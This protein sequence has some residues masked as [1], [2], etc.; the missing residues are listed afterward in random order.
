M[1]GVLADIVARHFGVSAKYE[2][3]KDADNLLLT[4]HSAKLARW[5]L[6][7][8]HRA[9]N[10]AIP[11]ELYSSL[12]LRQLAVLVHGYFQGDGNR[13]ESPKDGIIGRLSVCT[14]SKRLAHQVWNV[15][16][17][18]GVQPSLG[19]VQPKV[20]GVKSRQRVW[21]VMWQAERIQQKS[22]CRRTSM[23][24]ASVVRKVERRLSDC[25]VYTLEVEREH[26]YIAANMLTNNCIFDPVNNRSANRPL[27]GAPVPFAPGG[28]CPLCSGRGVQEVAVT[29]DITLKVNWEFKK[30]VAPP[31]DL[32]VRVPH[33]VVEV[34]SF[35][36]DV[37]K[38]LK[39]QYL[40][41]NLP[42][43]PYLRQEFVLMGE[44][45]D[46]SSMVPGRYAVSYWQ[47]KS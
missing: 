14:I 43:A 3:R 31:G 46:P 45:G 25:D 5:L 35:L 22:G 42:I 20:T 16:H 34:K 36:S 8:G 24:W 15:L 10:K 9:E 13:C 32:K 18:A 30:F 11:P 38:L 1:A 29:E 33:S 47:R 41:V 12:S 40:I 27:S 28:T 7:F 17:A 26:K 21:T 4:V 44:P 6:G 2:F 23:G 37:P 19:T 39:A